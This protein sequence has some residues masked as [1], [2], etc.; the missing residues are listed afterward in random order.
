MKCRVSCVTYEPAEARTPHEKVESTGFDCLCG[1]WKR[2]RRRTEVLPHNTMP[3][4]PVL[5]VELL[6]DEGCHLFF[7]CE[8]L[9]CLQR[10]G[11]IGSSEQWQSLVIQYCFYTRATDNQYPGSTVVTSLSSRIRHPQQPRVGGSPSLVLYP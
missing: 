9:Q 6:L 2:V 5:P 11:P 3:R 8:F 10:P 7:H 1:N 4:R